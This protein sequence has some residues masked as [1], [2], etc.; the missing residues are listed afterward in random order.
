M[1][2]FVNALWVGAG[3]F[4]GALSRYWLGTWIAQRFTGA[5]QFPW[6]TFVI[7]ITGSFI[8]GLFMVLITER[9]IAPPHWRLLI[10]VGFVGA[11]T[12]FSTFEYETLTLIENG[13]MLRAVAN[14]VFSV[15]AGL[16]AVWLGAKLGRT[17]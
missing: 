6:S 16:L 9:I 15:L 13:S 17:I 11:Y 12:T 1:S 5:A 14:V 7:N 8:L 2:F 10:A 3:G 4:L